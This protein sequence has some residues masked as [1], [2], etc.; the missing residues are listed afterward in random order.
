MMKKFKRIAALLLAGLM[1][2]AMFT[3]CSQEEVE[4][5]S[6]GKRYVQVYIDGINSYHPK[7]AQLENDKDLEA[8][9]KEALSYLD[10]NGYFNENLEAQLYDKYNIEIIIE[11]PI[12][13]D[14]EVIDGK[15]KAAPM[16]EE[17][18]AFLKGQYNETGG[19]NK[20]DEMTRI[21]AAYREIGG[22]IYCARAMTNDNL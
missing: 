3:A 20:F 15:C 12:S 18:L 10:E 9:C 16:T 8:Y 11:T 5:L 4:Q 13:D 21:G 7:D 1:M 22:N 17:L 2:L 19:A 6:L 14:Y